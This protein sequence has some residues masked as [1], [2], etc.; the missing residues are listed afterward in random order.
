MKNYAGLIRFLGLAIFLF[1]CGGGSSSPGGTGAD[2]G[3]GGGTGHVDGGGHV[4]SGG[5]VDLRLPANQG[6]NLNLSADKIS[7]ATSMGNFSGQWDKDHVS[8]SFNG[9]GIPVHVD[10]SGHLNI[11]IN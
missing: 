10:V 9:G 2:A 5:H 4:D 6:Y 7:P 3:D 1:A 11:E 8:G